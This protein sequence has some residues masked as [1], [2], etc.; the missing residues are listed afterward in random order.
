MIYWFLVNGGLAIVSATTSMPE[1][2]SA[3]V[4]VA[5][6]NTLSTSFTVVLAEIVA[7]A[8]VVGVDK[9]AAAAVGRSGCIVVADAIVV[10]VNKSLTAGWLFHS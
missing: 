2:L 10:A 1:S 9:T 6:T 4:P 7:F 5:L 8:I 3:T